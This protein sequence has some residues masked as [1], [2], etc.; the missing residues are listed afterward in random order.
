[1]DELATEQGEADRR[2]VG[3]GGRRSC[4]LGHEAGCLVSDP[5]SMI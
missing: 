4:V 3:G 1:V 5:L 2:G